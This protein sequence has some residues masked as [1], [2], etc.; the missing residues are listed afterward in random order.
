MF[1]SGPSKG[2]EDSRTSGDFGGEKG[3][4]D[5]GGPPISGSGVWWCPEKE[6]NHQYIV[7]TMMPRK[8]HVDE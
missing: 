8:G 4:V 1:G 5:Q 7:K 3:W 2:K 6:T